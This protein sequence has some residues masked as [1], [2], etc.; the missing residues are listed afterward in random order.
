[1]YLRSLIQNFDNEKTFDSL[2]FI[3]ER[4]ANIK[5]SCLMLK[6]FK[7]SISDSLYLLID[8]SMQTNNPQKKR[9]LH[10]EK[11][12]ILF[13]WQEPEAKSLEEGE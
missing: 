5:Q 13:E 10:C 2:A 8:V 1:M 7:L 11:H 4:K 9:V 6:P 12:R 3:S